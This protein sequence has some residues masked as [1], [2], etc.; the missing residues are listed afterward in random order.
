MFLI[1]LT[2]F[3]RLYL[4]VH[5][6]QDVLFALLESVLAILAVAK[7]MSYLELHPEKENM[8]LLAGFVLG[9][10]AILYISVKPYPMTYVDGKLLVDPQKMMKDGYG[11][12]GMLIAF[13]AA[14]F[15]EKTW[16]RFQP[17][18]LKGKGLFVALAGLVPLYLI[19][20]FLEDP[21]LI[22][23]G[24][25]WGKF[26]CQTILVFYIIAIWPLVIRLF[27]GREDTP[28]LQKEEVTEETE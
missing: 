14:R 18:G 26:T 19:L 16:I 8:S 4:G 12:I 2:M 22:T 27:C 23:L 25:L 5:T 28:A 6:P 21:L 15:V 10:L 9:W 7:I 11:D 13:C 20:E 17:A 3:S 1:L 24:T